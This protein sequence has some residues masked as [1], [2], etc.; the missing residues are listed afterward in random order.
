MGLAI[1]ALQFEL[2]ACAALGPLLVTSL[3]PASTGI[4]CLRYIG[5]VSIEEVT[6]VLGSRVMAGGQTCAAIAPL[7]FLWFEGVA[8]RVELD[9]FE[10]GEAASSPIVFVANEVYPL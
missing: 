8:G 4:T 2:D 9:V 10:S 1:V 5:R 6:H 3:L 7:S